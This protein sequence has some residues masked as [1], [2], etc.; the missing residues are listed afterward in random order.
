MAAAGFLALLVADALPIANLVLQEELG[1]SL[2]SSGVAHLEPLALFGLVALGLGVVGLLRETGDRCYNRPD[3]VRGGRHT[4]PGDRATYR[5]RQQLP[6]RRPR[7]RPAV[8]GRRDAA[9]R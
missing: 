9:R 5:P 3:R 2:F 8:P 6:H 7:P 4:E 1:L